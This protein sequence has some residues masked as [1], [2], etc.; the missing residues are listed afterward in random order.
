[1]AAWLKSEKAQSLFLWSARIV[2][3]V[4]IFMAFMATPWFWRIESFRIGEILL[5]GLGGALGILGAPAAIFLLFGMAEFYFRHD[6]S[7]SSDKALW[8]IV[9]LGTAWFGAAL[10]FFTVYQKQVRCSAQL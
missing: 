10:Y 9:V 5:R 3:C 8:F 1:M 6:R 4:G 2:V 7:P